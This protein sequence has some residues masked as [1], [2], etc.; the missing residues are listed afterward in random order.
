MLQAETK[1]KTIDF[2]FWMQLII[3]ILIISALGACFSKCQYTSYKARQEREAYHQQRRVTTLRNDPQAPSN[4]QHIDISNT[5]GIVATYMIKQ[6]DVNNDGLS[7]CID[8]AILFYQYFPDKSKVCIL[9]NKN[10]AQ[11]F[12]HMFN[13]VLIDG[14]WRAIEPQAYWKNHVDYFMRAVWG[15]QY[16]HTLNRDVTAEFSKFVR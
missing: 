5:L 6:A 10:E 7:N 13:A 9:V 8:A 12:H 15:N 3:L 16:D 1:A 14:V 2:S 11:H 4:S